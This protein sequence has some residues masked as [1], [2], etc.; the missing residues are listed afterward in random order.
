MSE[1]ALTPMR[2]LERLRRLSIYV[3]DTVVECSLVREELHRWAAEIARLRAERDGLKAQ[4]EEFWQ[5]V[6]RGYDI[7]SRQEI[8]A[9]DEVGTVFSSP[10]QMAMHL[11]WKR[12][13]SVVELKAQQEARPSLYAGKRNY[14]R[15]V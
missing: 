12:N 11:I 4:V 1:E 10:I 6:E 15:K 7:E 8:E 2:A 13:P 5:E 9:S 14:P 3:D